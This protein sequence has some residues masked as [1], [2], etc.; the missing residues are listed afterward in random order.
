[1]FKNINITKKRT[2]FVI[3][4]KNCFLAITH[5]ISIFRTKERFLVITKKKSFLAI[6]RS[7]STFHRKWR[8]FLIT[9]KRSLLWPWKA[10]FSVIT[11]KSHNSFNIDISMKMLTFH[12]KK[13]FS[14]HFKKNLVFGHIYENEYML[15]RTLFKG[16]FFWRYVQKCQHI[17]ENYIVFKLLW[18]N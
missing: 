18:E 11:M 10:D 15:V 3:S 6:T 4:I 2:I 13:I 7:E 1:M 8:Y 9:L 14:D 12:R 16:L 5:L 17:K